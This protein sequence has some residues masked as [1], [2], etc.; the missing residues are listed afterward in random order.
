MC[1]ALKHILIEFIYF[2]FQT[3]MDDV[4]CK[5]LIRLRDYV[6]QDYLSEHFYVWEGAFGRIANRYL[7]NSTIKDV[8]PADKPGLSTFLHNT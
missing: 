4:S 7:Y 1:H 6:D 8:W 5:R 2:F 3:G